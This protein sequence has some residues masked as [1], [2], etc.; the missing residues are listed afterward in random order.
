VETVWIF[1]HGTSRPLAFSPDG[2]SWF[3]R[4]GQPWAFTGGDSGWLYAF[5]SGKALGFF[6]D[7][8][9]FS[10]EGKPLY[11]KSP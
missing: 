9:F 10:P 1:E 7:N 2:T 8:N 5:G 3:T 6:S 11:S 4:D